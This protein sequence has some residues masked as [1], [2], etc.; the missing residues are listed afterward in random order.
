MSQWKRGLNDIPEVDCYFGGSVSCKRLKFTTSN[1]YYLP[2]KVA[3]ELVA[4]CEEGALR[5]P[6][7]LLQPLTKHIVFPNVFGDSGAASSTGS[8][9]DEKPE[10]LYFSRRMAKQA[11]ELG[12]PLPSMRSGWPGVASWLAS[13]L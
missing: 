4:A 13:L 12:H 9:D 6:D 10:D 3:S 7:V 11:Q 1:A 8:A 2:A 5:S